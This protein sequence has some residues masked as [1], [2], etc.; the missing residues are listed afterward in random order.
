MAIGSHTDIAGDRQSG[1]DV[2]TQNGKYYTAVRI[3]TV[4]YVY[5][6]LCICVYVHVLILFSECELSF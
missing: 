4:V 5:L 6:Y 1:Q 2:R 3:D